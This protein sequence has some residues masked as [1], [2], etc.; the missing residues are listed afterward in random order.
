MP[1]DVNLAESVFLGDR[2]K[3]R[4]VR[5]HMILLKT[6][7]RKKGSM[8]TVQGDGRTIARNT[9]F[10]KELSKTV[11][12]S[13]SG[14]VQDDDVNAPSDNPPPVSPD[15][16]VIPSSNASNPTV[17]CKT[18]NAPRLDNPVH[19]EG[20][21]PASFFRVTCKEQSQSVPVPPPL[22]KSSGKR[23]PRKIFEL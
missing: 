15:V 2:S 3:R 17:P 20:M 11:P 9:S 22:R 19:P 12:N 16:S 1:F 21:M 5:L 10:F 23:I 18:T 14:D 4:K 8:I 13:D 6:V 7:M